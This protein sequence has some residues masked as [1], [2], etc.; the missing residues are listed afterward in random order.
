MQVVFHAEQV[1]GQYAIHLPTPMDV[2]VLVPPE[3]HEDALEYLDSLP[4]SQVQAVRDNIVKMA[5]RLQYAF[6]GPFPHPG[7]DASRK[8]HPY[9]YPVFHVISHSLFEPMSYHTSVK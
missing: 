8:S 9:G 7:T 4:T 5:P 6:G 3:R 1:E 2:C